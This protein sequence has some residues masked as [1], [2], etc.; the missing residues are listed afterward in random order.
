VEHPEISSKITARKIKSIEATGASVV[1]TGCPGCRI[2][3]NA[4]LD[5]EKHIRV[6]HP[7]ELV[8]MALEGGS[9]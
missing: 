6:L 8:K 3:I 2:T 1:A 7:I 9:S 5:S 4:H